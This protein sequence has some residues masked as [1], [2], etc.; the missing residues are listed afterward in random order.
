M[1]DRGTGVSR[2]RARNP[3]E[4]EGLVCRRGAWYRRHVESG[5]MLGNVLTAIVTPFHED[6]SDRLRRVPAPRAAPR[7]Q[8]LRRDRR[9]GDD[10][11]KP[12][13]HRFA[14]ASISSAPRSRRSARTHRS[15]RGPARTRPRIRSTSPNR[16]TS[17][18]S[19]DSSIVT[20]YYNKPPQRGIVAHFEAI[21]AASDL[22]IV[23]YN[24]PS[25]VVINIEPETISRLAEIETVRAV[26]QANDDLDAGAAH[27]RDRARSVRGRRQ[28]DP[29]VPGARR[30]R[31]HLRAHARRRT[32]GRGAG[33]G[34]AHGRPRAGSRARRGPRRRR[35]TC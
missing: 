17:S 14:S 31:R 33:A 13:A 27:R 2:R 22:P 16:R 21:A 15:S 19:T 4:I 29:A 28:P 20:P 35:T 23:V 9:R 18:A 10:R 30:R 3:A 25:R 11:R 24:I 8:R 7:R 1:L 26:K 5:R 32:A 12:D 34:G 6:G